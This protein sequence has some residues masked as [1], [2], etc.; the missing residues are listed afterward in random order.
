MANMSEVQDS[1][2][3]TAVRTMLSAVKPPRQI[4][5]VAVWP[6]PRELEVQ[7]L[8]HYL[9]RDRQICLGPEQGG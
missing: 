4:G 2:P 5:G 1:A 7:I 9:Q 8:C 3:N 6:I